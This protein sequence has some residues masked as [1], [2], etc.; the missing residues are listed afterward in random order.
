MAKIC[1]GPR[2]GNCDR[3]GVG[4][5]GRPHGYGPA[6]Y[7]VDPEPRRSHWDILCPTCLRQTSEGSRPAPDVIAE[8][9]SVERRD[10]GEVIVEEARFDG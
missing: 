6:A 10:D 9:S 4:L 3:C 7:R 5:I 1:E 8:I 2:G